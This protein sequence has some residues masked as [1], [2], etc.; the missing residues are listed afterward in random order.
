MAAG[1]FDDAAEL[2]REIDEE[3]RHPLAAFSLGYLYKT[4]Q[5][6]HQDRA[7]A[8]DWFEK[9]ARREVPSGANEY[10]ICLRD[11]LN[12]EPDANGAVEEFIAAGEAG[13]TSA[14]CAAGRILIAS[15]NTPGNSQTG[16]ELCRRSAQ[17]G[18]ADDQLWLGQ[19]LSDPDSPLHDPEEA[20]FWLET[21]AEGNNAEAQYLVGMLH[22]SGDD[23]AAA[24]HWL[25]KAASQG[26]QAAYQPTGEAYYADIRDPDTGEPDGT[27]VAK[28]YMWL[29][30][31][32][33]VEENS[34]RRAKAADMR[35][36][37][38]EMMPEDWPAVLDEKVDAHFADL[39]ATQPVVSRVD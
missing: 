34:D 3:F 2:Y 20:G 11:G 35:E 5:G 37:L 16:L 33:R 30:A 18:H 15:D 9:A 29:T 28:A 7:T 12:G 6:V 21:A 38:L 27:R 23:L 8:C 10:A 1:Q 22:R 39:Q 36:K 25:E 14:F 26:Y 13:Q 19:L 32:L 4:G 24:Q 17:A 31:S